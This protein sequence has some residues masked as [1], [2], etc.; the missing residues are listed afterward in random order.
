MRSEINHATGYRM[1]RIRNKAEK[2][3]LRTRVSFNQNC[4][5]CTCERP[6]ILL[7]KQN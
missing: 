1:S 6:V 7:Q 4:H 3:I 5:I 2:S